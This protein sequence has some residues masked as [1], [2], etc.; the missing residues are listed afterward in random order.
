M[1]RTIDALADAVAERLGVEPESIM[2]EPPNRISLTVE[3]V[4]RLLALA[5]E[6]R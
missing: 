3:Q 6:E 2:T 4:E 5:G 1:K